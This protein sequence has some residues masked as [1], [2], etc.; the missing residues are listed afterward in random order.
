MKKK[1]F[2]AKKYGWGWTP[3]S[4]EGWVLVTAYCIAI[5]YI[6]FKIDS[7]SHSVSDTLISFF[8]ILVLLTAILMAISYKTGEKPHWQWGDRSGTKKRKSS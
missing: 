1:W 8:P 4:F 6:F 2:K 3:V 7:S 5:F